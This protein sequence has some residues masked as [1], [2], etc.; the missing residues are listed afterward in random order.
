MGKFQLRLRRVSNN[1]N[2]LTLPNGDYLLFSY[3]TPVA[4]W[5]DEGIFKT[6]IMFSTTTSRHINSFANGKEV[7]EVTSYVFEDKYFDALK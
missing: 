1:Q 4:I 6:D 7:N 2:V 5:T 3:E